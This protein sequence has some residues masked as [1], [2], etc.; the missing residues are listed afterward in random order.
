MSEATAAHRVVIIGGG[1]GGLSCATDLR[2]FQGRITLIDRRNFHLFQPLLYQVATGALSPANIASPLRSILKYQTNAKIIMSEVS[3][4]DVTAKEVLFRDG[5]RL[6]FDTLVVSGGSTHHYFGKDALWEPFAPGLKSLEDATEIRRRVLSAFERA[7]R[8]PDIA[9]RKKHLSF[10]VVGGGP[11]GVEMAGAI[12]E[13]ARQTLRRDFRT[14]DP[15]DARVILVENSDRVLQTFAET[16]SKRAGESLS[17]IGVELW[18]NCRVTDIAA[19]RVVIDRAGIHESVP[20]ECVV[21]A[22]GVKANPLAKMLAEAV[23]GVEIDKAGRLAVNADCTVG[24]RADIFAL[25][26]MALMK[27]ADGKQLPGVAPVAVQQGQYVAGLLLRRQKGQSAP[28]PFRYWDKGSMATIGR[29]RAVLEAGKIK[30]SGFIAWLAWLFI[31]ILY[32]ARFENRVLVLFQW[33]WNY[34]TRNRTARL[35][36]GE[37][38]NR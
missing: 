19:D 24:T 30:M 1:F 4:F 26:D 21:W 34:A 5:Y 15:A 13:L 28:G 32:L 38:A 29:S 20:T 9:N 8:D 37:R 27:D 2:K 23:G 31:H 6:P 35:I 7:E 12:A 17:Q 36:T 11:T 10:V 25:G 3:G 14:I 22:A 16:L 33:S 18:L